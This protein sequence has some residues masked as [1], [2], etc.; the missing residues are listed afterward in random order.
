[1]PALSLS[2]A[3]LLLKKHTCGPREVLFGFDAL[4][5]VVIKEAAALLLVLAAI[6]VR[7]A[8]VVVIVC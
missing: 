1:V 3:S 5:V 2:Y 6:V 8:G 7:G 4:V